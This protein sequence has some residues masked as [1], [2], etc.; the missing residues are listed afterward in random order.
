MQ[1]I[2]SIHIIFG[3]YPLLNLDET[4]WEKVILF[5]KT[6]CILFLVSSFSFFSSLSPFPPVKF[7]A[8]ACENQIFQADLRTQDRMMTKRISIQSGKSYWN[9]ITYKFLYHSTM[10]EKLF[11]IW[12]YKTNYSVLLFKPILYQKRKKEK[13]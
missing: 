12:F 1:N 7:I 6:E 3:H 11:N 10:L 4:G 8:M 9:R 5:E 2:C 13:R